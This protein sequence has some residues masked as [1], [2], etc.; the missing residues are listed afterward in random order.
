MPRADDL[1][2]PLGVKAPAA[3]D[4]SIPVPVVAAEPVASAPQAG[5][6]QPQAGMMQPQQP[7]MMQGG[8]QGGGMTQQQLAMMMQTQQQAG[9]MQGGMVQGGMMP[10]PVMMQGSMAPDAAQ[11][12]RERRELENRRE[13]QARLDQLER[14]NQDHLERQERQ[15]RLERQERQERADR[16]ERMQM[17]RLA[18]QQ[19]GGAGGS[20][21]ADVFVFEPLVAQ[22]QSMARFN[23]PPTPAPAHSDGQ[24][25]FWRYFT[26]DEM[27]VCESPHGGHNACCEVAICGMC[28]HG[29][30]QEWATGAKDKAGEWLFWPCIGAFLVESDRRAI[31]KKIHAFHKERGD[32]TAPA[33]PHHHCGTCI[34][35]TFC[36]WSMAAQNVQ[37]MKNFKHIQNQ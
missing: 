22:A 31:E 13:H 12:E 1:K 5:M 20:S 27:W 33:E 6:M 14:Q 23:P 34:A 19:G 29:E 21:G 4:A 28:L 7:H 37:V 9:M 25:F 3:L 8:M 18:M 36:C 24:N 16:N 2:A 30:I 15:E 11:Y 26:G 17:E 35:A 10:Q 32:P